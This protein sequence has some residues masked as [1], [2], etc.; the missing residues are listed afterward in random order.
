MV[1]RDAQGGLRIRVPARILGDIVAAG[2]GFN[3]NRP[4]TG[5]VNA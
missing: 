1:S 3:C 4:A 5:V 2:T